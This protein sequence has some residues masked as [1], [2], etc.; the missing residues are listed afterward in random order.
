MFGIGAQELIVILVVAL[1]VFGPKRL[2]ELARSLGKGLAEF[3]RAS[4]DL[5]GSFQETEQ[6]IKA[7][8]EASTNQP[9]EPAQAGTNLEDSAPASPAK[10]AT[11]PGTQAEPKTDAQPG[12]PPSAP[13]DKEPSGSV[14]G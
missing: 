2:P 8:L 7:P 14:G 6:S 4:S 11:A 1:V 12:D 5:R 9:P 10:T 13:A 3:R